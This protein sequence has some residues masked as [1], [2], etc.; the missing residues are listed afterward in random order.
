MFK[1]HQTRPY[2]KREAPFYKPERSAIK[3]DR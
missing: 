1:T 3:M 2:M